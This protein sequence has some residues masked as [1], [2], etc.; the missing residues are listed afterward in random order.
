[1]AEPSRQKI[2][3]GYEQ[4]A[5]ELIP[6]YENLSPETVLAP[7]LDYL[8]ETGADV[9][10]VGAGP[11]TVAAWLASRGNHVTA[12]EPVS[13]FR[14]YG[15]KTYQHLNISWHEAYLPELINSGPWRRCFDIALA[16]GVLHHLTP[17]D[18]DRAIHMLSSCLKPYGRLILLL[19][20]GPCPEDRPGFEIPVDKVLHSADCA[21][22]QVEYTSHKASIQDGNR[23]AGVT[24]T[25]LV[26]SAPGVVS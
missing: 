22:L 19:R 23:R 21:G 15:Q 25:W 1:M 2:I 24:W 9:L 26:L 11:G 10:D 14:T 6:V 20:H 5:A 8:P 12:I 3:E 13:G 7:V 18:Q 4:A 16:I 17:Q